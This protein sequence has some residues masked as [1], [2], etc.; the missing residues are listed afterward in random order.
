MN[1]GDIAPTFHVRRNEVDRNRVVFA[2]KLQG[3]IGKNHAEAPCC[4][5]RT[6]LEQLDLVARMPTFPHRGEIEPTRSTANHGNAHWP[7]SHG[8][9][10]GRAASKISSSFA[11]YSKLLLHDAIGKREE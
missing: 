11:P 1:H 6:L 5:G 8:G 4:V 2:Q 10:S 3:A 9:F 7:M